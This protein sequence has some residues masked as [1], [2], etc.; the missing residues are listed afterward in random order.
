M[1]HLKTAILLIL[2]LALIAAPVLG[3]VPGSVSAIAFGAKGDGIT[4]DTA[5]I[6]KALD[7]LDG[8]GGIVNLPA[9]RY[10]LSAALR[11]PGGVTLLGEG[12]RWENSATGLVVPTN[13]FFRLRDVP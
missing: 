13:G 9:G 3:A 11:V 10:V 5:A 7:S 6:Q 2:A 1:V 12:A 8:K 4:D